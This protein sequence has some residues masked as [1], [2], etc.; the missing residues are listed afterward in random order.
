MIP[1]SVPPAAIEAGLLAMF[2]VTFFVI[3]ALS[4]IT[5]VLRMFRGR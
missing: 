2:M 5:F 3:G 4:I 1:I